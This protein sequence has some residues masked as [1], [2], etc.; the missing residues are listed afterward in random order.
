MMFGREQFHPGIIIEPVEGLRVDDENSQNAFIDE[1]WRAEKL[2]V[3][4]NDVGTNM[5]SSGLTSWR[6][7]PALQHIPAFSEKYVMIIIC[8]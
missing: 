4:Y 2:T 1:I 8:I 6:R 7:T 3:F 5:Y